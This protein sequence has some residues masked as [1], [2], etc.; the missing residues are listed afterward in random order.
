MGVANMASKKKSSTKRDDDATGRT[1]LAVSFYLDDDII[2]CM[3]AYKAAQKM[4][5]S[6]K[7]VINYALKKLLTE[8][9]FYP[10]KGST[11]GS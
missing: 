4:P 3:E 6:N 11:N 2:P 9:G 10:A 1:G 8:E 5:P 7:A